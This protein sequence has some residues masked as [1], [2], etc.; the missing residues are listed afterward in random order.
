MKTIGDMGGIVGVST[1]VEVGDSL[2][3][4]VCAFLRRTASS[5]AGKRGLS[6]GACTKSAQF[7]HRP[8]R[9]ESK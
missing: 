3:S 9:T 1:S 5:G 8:V 4:P 6:E 7:H 2:N